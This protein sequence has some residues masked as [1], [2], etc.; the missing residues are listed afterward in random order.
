VQRGEMLLRE[1]D[2]VDAYVVS[3]GVVRETHRGAREL[4]GEHFSSP[5]LAQLSHRLVSA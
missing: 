5:A 1:A 2:L 4:E 3:R